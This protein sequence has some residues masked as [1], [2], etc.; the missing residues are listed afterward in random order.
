MNKEGLV[1]AMS[2][3]ADYS[4]SQYNNATQ[5]G[6]PT[7]SSFKP[8]T[9]AIAIEDGKLSPY[10][11]VSNRTFYIRDRGSRRAI[12]GGGGGGEIGVARALYTSNNTAAMWAQKLAGTSRVASGARTIFGIDRDLPLVDTLTLGVA[13]ITPLQMAEAYSVFQNE[14]ARVEPRMIISIASKEEGEVYTSRKII[15]PG[16]LKRS[17]A[18]A[19][20]A[21]L[22][23]VVVASGG[24]GKAAGIATN[25]RGKTGTTTANKDAWFC[26]Y[27]NELVGIVW[28]GN[29]S[30]YK[31]SDGTIRARHNRMAGVMG[32]QVPA[33]VWGRI[34]SRAQDMLGEEYADISTRISRTRDASEGATSRDDEPDQAGSNPGRGGDE[35]ETSPD[36]PTEPSP[37][38]PTT[39][40]P[41]AP[42]NE[43]DPVPFEPDPEP[44]RPPARAAPDRSED[45]GGVVTLEVCAD[46]RQ[47]ASVA[48]PERVTRTFPR[49]SQPRST[50]SRHRLD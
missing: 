34:M 4:R 29:T 7:G 41:R 48:C 37:D 39:A 6:L 16:R 43:P 31:A 23:S 46:T 32:G 5:G 12:Q 10:G 49:G 15:Y 42:E 18:R 40:S 20:D 50:C 27:T 47:L 17:T 36:I 14:G 38:R 45:S 22:R 28:V 21:M 35:A 8:F 1:L 44:A 13:D 25:A 30:F 24:T 26:G 33:P 11:S 9:Y 3:G 2:G 19:L